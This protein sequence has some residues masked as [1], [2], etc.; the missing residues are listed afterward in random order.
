MTKA[1]LVKPSY[2][3]WLIPSLLIFGAYVTHGLPYVI[4]S[5]DWKD[6]GYGYGEISKRHYARCSYLGADGFITEYPTNGKCGW[7]RFPKGEIKISPLSRVDKL[8]ARMGELVANA[9]A[10]AKFHDGHVLDALKHQGLAGLAVSDLLVTMVSGL[11]DE[12][13]GCDRRPKSLIVH[14][15]KPV[16]DVI[17]GFECFHAQSYQTGFRQCKFLIDKGISHV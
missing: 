6:Q 10:H 16:L 9:K 1:R 15:G 4:W 13:I 8:D 14:R 3:A 5:Y 2:F 7:F 17:F 11:Q 12:V